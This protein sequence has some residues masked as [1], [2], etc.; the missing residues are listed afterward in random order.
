[1]SWLLDTCVISEW[2]HKTPDPK[3]IKWVDE[4]DETALYLSVLTLG[5]LEK[6]VMRLSQGAKKVRIEDWIRNDLRDRFAGRIIP[7]SEEVAIQ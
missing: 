6:G 4:K 2:T 5:E 3:V 1:M 7:V